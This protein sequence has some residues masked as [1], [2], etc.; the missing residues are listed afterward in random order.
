MVIAIDGPAGS[1]K[2]TIARD[3]AKKLNILYVDSGAMYRA[4]TL[5]LL[6]NNVSFTNEAVSKHLELIS[7]RLDIVNDSQETF[8]N[9]S[10]VSNEIRSTDISSSV[11]LVASLPS[12]RWWL[13]VQQRQL[14]NNNDI[15]MDGRDIGTVVFPNAEVKFFLTANIDV[16]ANRR[17]KELLENGNTVEFEKVRS[18]MI[19]RDTLDSERTLAPLVKANDAIEIDTS[20][21]SIQ[22]LLELMSDQITKFLKSK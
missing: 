16:R 18:E 15:I 20:S 9:N 6:Q 8:L 3:L 17:T 1:G 14:S 4:V 2:S 7:I 22:E 11:S 13:L 5:S 21:S 12:V 10:N 19:R